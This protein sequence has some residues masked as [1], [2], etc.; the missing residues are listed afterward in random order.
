MLS[1]QN[2]SK[3]K[4]KGSITVE[5]SLSL[6]LFVFVMISIIS[7]INICR[8]QTKVGN[9]LHL[10]ALD[11]S[12]YSYLYEAAGLYDLD[13]TIQQSGQSA[14]D[15]LVEKA[16]SADALLVNAENVFSLIESSGVAVGDLAEGNSDLEETANTLQGNYQAGQDNF[17]SAK[18]N[19]GKIVD[20]AK[21]IAGNPVGFLKILLQYGIGSGYNQVKNL[22]AGAMAKG[23]MISHI[24]A[25]EVVEDAD[26]YLRS[27]GVVDGLDG[28]HFTASNIYTGDEYSDIN[29]V[30]MYKVK[31]F[32]L[33]GDA[34]IPFSQSA[35][36][37]AWLMGDAKSSYN[38]GSNQ[39]GETEE[40][41]GTEENDEP[42]PT[43]T[44]TP[45]PNMWNEPDFKKYATL[46]NMVAEEY[47]ASGT[48][49][50]ANAEGNPYFGYDEATNTLYGGTCKD[51]VQYYR[52]DDKLNK[53]SLKSALRASLKT[54]YKKRES[55]VKEGGG[56]YDLPEEVSYMYVIYVP[57]N[58]SQEDIDFIMQ[59]VAEWQE[60]QEEVEGI[61]NFN[62]TLEKFGGDSVKQEE[63]QS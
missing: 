30:V 2:Y 49:V 45:A 60:Q 54:A 28:M 48:Y 62:I 33:L 56:V 57:E 36:T 7:L 13:V 31:L 11:L 50:K 58:A 5:A 42:T 3:K 17:D 46:S 39:G 35:S 53:S 1:R 20:E 52:K 41:G 43:P 51:I 38:G 32:P 34:S 15:T 22:V 21:D 6:V 27:L 16:S 63:E 14:G 47:S 26:V 59:V 23:I 29:L 25:E 55:F 40:N 12:H 18:A 4:N 44:P 24:E 19:F 8:V 10:A 61:S 9:A 37:R